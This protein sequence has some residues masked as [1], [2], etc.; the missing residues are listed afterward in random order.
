MISIF[1]TQQLAK[2]SHRRL[3]YYFCSGERHDATTVLRGLI[4]QL[5][6]MYRDLAAQV[7]PLMEPPERRKG[8]LTSGE[9][10]WN[11]FESLVCSIGDKRLHVV[12]DG[13]DEC[14]NQ[15]GRWLASRLARYGRR[16]GRGNMSVIVLSRHMS[17]LEMSTT[18]R[19]DP[20]HN[21]FVSADVKAYI[22][23]RVE[24]LSLQLQF[25]EQQKDHIVNRLLR[26]SEGTFLWVGFVM[27]ELFMEDTISD[28]MTAIEDIPAGLPAF[29]A[30]MLKG[31]KLVHKELSMRLLAWLIT[32]F[33]RPTV[34]TLIDVLRCPTQE[35]LSQRQA[36]LDYI[37]HCAPMLVLQ[38][39]G[40]D[41]VH[42]SA[43]D[44]LLRSTTVLGPE[45]EAFH[46]NINR[47]HL[48]AASRCLEALSEQTYLQHYALLNW[49]KHAKTLGHLTT[50][51]L[52]QHWLFFGEKSGV[53]DRWWRKYSHHFRGIPENPPPRLHIACFLGFEAWIKTML[54]EEEALTSSWTD[55]L[56]M[57]C[58]NGW[59]TLRYAAESGSDATMA[60]LLCKGPPDLWWDAVHELWFHRVNVAEYEKVVRHLLL[61][62]ANP[63]RSI[64]NAIEGGD[65]VSVRVLT[66]QHDPDHRMTTSELNGWLAVAQAL[67]H[68]EV[69]EALVHSGADP[70]HPILKVVEAGNAHSV[71]I[72]MECGLEHN[73]TTVELTAW[74][75]MAWSL[76]HIAVAEVL[77]QRGA[78]SDAIKCVGQSLLRFVV[79]DNHLSMFRALLAS[80]TDINHTD[81]AGKT[82]LYHAV[83]TGNLK[84][85]KILLHN[86]A[87]PN[88][89]GCCTSLPLHRAVSEGN[90]IM[91]QL[92]LAR[93][94][95]V[96]LTDG[97][98]MTP[99]HLAV[100]RGDRDMTELLLD[101]GASPDLAD[102]GTFT[103]LHR[104]VSTNDLLVTDVLLNGN[105][106]PNLT[107][108]TGATPLHD[109]AM[110]GRLALVRTLLAGGA[111]RNRLNGQGET[112]R[113]IA[114]RW[115]YPKI[116]RQ[117]L[118]DG[119][120][121]MS[122][123][124]QGSTLYQTVDS[125]E[126][127]I[128]AHIME[129]GSSTLGI[130]AYE[131]R[132]MLTPSHNSA[133]DEMLSDSDRHERFAQRTHRALTKALY[134]II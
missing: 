34:E 43:K 119:T 91:T 97:V 41:F 38:E 105:A 79:S 82:P 62:G 100:A 61:R 88:F 19:L 113:I 102:G 89:R 68:I 24:D 45:L 35:G 37:R 77:L 75:L 104:A 18:I 25:T 120:T 32:T 84:M 126:L 8:T 23:T 125:D 4:W 94:A 12:I 122:R 124:E 44:C 93:S 50:E 65:S 28:V 31:I 80:D 78:N 56:H 3:V 60:L 92:L 71:R 107:D 42:Q 67:R 81:D 53:R 83:A 46:V 112:A 87:D 49:P 55:Q 21:A 115:S 123:Q 98:G 15:S 30:R 95:D 86:G 63:R 118:A 47:A 66:K 11:L 7:L 73:V 58:P 26:K 111:D 57:S 54:T 108:W 117:L 36:T 74:S 5:I 39:K 1:L 106:N 33:Q 90:L 116:L 27:A 114:A 99:L 69:M 9:T 127:E 134:P 40:V 76:E 16:D 2:P 72:L 70:L 51:L 132:S 110:F 103:P 121:T 6:D 22:K 64:L 96:D 29:Y 85:T 133:S 128:L 131:S 52:E 129:K 59:S 13:L 17:A 20:D 10:L 101:G 14:N 130:S 109:A 48:Y